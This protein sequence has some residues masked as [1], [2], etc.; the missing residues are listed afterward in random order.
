MIGLV[1][2]HQR[3]LLTTSPATMA[4][5]FQNRGAVMVLLNVTM[6]QMNSTV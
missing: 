3:V 2:H 5:A 6:I 4:T 1:Q